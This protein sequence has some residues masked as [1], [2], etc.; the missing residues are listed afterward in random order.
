MS[1]EQV[2]IPGVIVAPGG[3]IPI[4][5]PSITQLEIDYVTD[6]A[7]TGWYGQANDYLVK[8][9]D[10]F[11]KFLDIEH[12]VP[13]PS[14]TSG[15]H[16]AL[17]ALDVGPGDEVIIPETTWIAS[18]APITYVGA[19]PVFADVD[20]KTWCMCPH[21]F[22]RAI[23]PAT[24]AVIVVDIYGNMANYD[25]ISEIARENGIRVIEDAAEAIGATFRGRPAGTLGD[26]GIFSFHGSKTLSTGEGGMLVTADGDIHRRVN[27]LRDHGRVPGDSSFVNA[28]V[29]FKYKM[30]NLQA[31]V[32]LGQ[33]ERIGEIMEM[34]RQAF[35]WYHERL[36]S[37]SGICMND[38]GEGVEAAY[39]L[40]SLV[41]D[42][43]LPLEKTEVRAAL[44]EHGI[45][46]RP[47]FSPLSSLPA[48]SAVVAD[49]NYRERN[50]VSYELGDKGINLPSSLSLRED[51]VEFI[52]GKLL[53]ILRKTDF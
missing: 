1:D 29:A 8:F 35:R 50:P 51:Q 39:W 19:T 53:P 14:A 48:Y 22:E 47:F 45:D 36:G 3:R 40:V 6:A 25:A 52:C 38:P 26:V 20:P 9:Q 16:L 15:L 21:S 17:A 5:G 4:A 41:W 33:I 46:T 31:A 30:S 10:A 44:L 32:G 24:K 42:S 23:T 27:F 18:S 37:L 13:L 28:E 49:T 34:K 11:A 12:A 7:T 43:S 2:K